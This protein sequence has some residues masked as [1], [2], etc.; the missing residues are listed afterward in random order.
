MDVS[1]DCGAEAPEE[2]EVGSCSMGWA[3]YAICGIVVPNQGLNPHPI[4][5]AGA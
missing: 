5:K 1:L 3:V 4:A 2:R